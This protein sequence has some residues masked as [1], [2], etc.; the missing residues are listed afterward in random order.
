[1]THI[2]KS[3]KL[4]LVTTATNSYNATIKKLTTD[5][6][7]QKDALIRLIGMS[8]KKALLIGI[9]YTNTSNELYGCINDTANVQQM[10]AAKFGYPLFT[11]MTDKTVKRPSKQNILV[12]LT[13]LLVR[14][15]PGD[16]LFFLY[17]GHGTN[18]SDLNKDEEDGQDEL[19]VPIDATSIHSCILDDELYLLIQTHL[20]RGV[21]LVMLFDSCFSGTILD[22]KYNYLVSNDNDNTTN[23]TLAINENSSDTL[24]QVCVISGCK[25]N[26]TSA[27]A[28]VNYNSKNMYSGAMTYAFLNALHAVKDVTWLQLITHMRDILK[29]E[30]YEQ[31]PQFSTSTCINIATEKVF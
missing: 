16:N 29:A 19:I 24:G 28:Y 27:D 17:S 25:D 23:N 21:K 2:S 11:L 1:M 9:N 6:N 15:K 4:I 3:A 20:K 8:S 30:G 12:E 26:Q 14:S 22:L 18:T 5:Y 13:N 31:I 10:L 7:K